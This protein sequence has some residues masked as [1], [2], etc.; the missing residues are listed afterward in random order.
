LPSSIRG[1][2]ISLFGVALEHETRGRLLGARDWT[3]REWFIA[4][5]DSLSD[6]EAVASVGLAVWDGDDLIVAGYD[7]DSELAARTRSET[8]KRAIKA[9]WD[10][11]RE[12]RAH[13]GVH[14]D[15]STSVST[16]VL[17]GEDRRREKTRIAKKAG[18]GAR[19]RSG[20]GRGGLQDP[21]Q[22]SKTE[23]GAEPEDRGDYPGW[24]NDVAHEPGEGA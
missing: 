12:A 17:L 18:N 21:D 24:E 22:T 19:I 2:W 9:R 13:T 5:G 23:T 20:S 6:V 15:V 3:D 10:R 4:T 11:V 14:T 8:A 16:P 1:T 7:P